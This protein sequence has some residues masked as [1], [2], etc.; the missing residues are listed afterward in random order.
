MKD[1]KVFA[2][3]CSFYKIF[4]IF[5]IGCIIGF[6]YESIL[7]VFQT[8]S[9]IN[10]Q[11]LIFGPFAPVYGFG[12]VL[13]LVVLKNIKNS[14]VIF[15]VSGI[16]GGILEYLYSFFQEKYFGTISWDYSNF[17]TN[18]DGRTTI[19][20]CIGWGL[21]GLVYIKWIYP[22][23]SN[24]IEKIP[25]KI[26]VTLV[27]A[28]IIFMVFNINITVFSAIRQK[29]RKENIQ[30]KNNIDV[31]YDKYFPDWVMEKRHPN[32]RFVTS[33]NS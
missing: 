21:L 22:A 15:I 8:G 4:L 2:K 19:I 6:L 1:K 12:A 24:I 26:G 11:E 14:F 28:L 27:W 10:K 9:F 17:T 16:S 23:L 18:V 29:E 7:S 5:I 3:D 13:F 31:F 30:P 25:S 33:K 32:R 20:Y